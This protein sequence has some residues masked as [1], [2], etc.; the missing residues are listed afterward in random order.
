MVEKENDGNYKTIWQYTFKFRRNEIEP[1]MHYIFN[2]LFLILDK[3]MDD[4]G[5]HSVSSY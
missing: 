1:I 3:E 4:D 2:H 5:K